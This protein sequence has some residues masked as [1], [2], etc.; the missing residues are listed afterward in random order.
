MSVALA[1]WRRLEE[2]RRRQKHWRRWGTYLSE[3]QWG[4]VREDYSA[5]GTAWDYFPFEHAHLRAYRWGEDGLLGYSDNHGRL[6][7][8]IALWNEK[9][10][11]LKERLFG[12]AGPLGNHGEDVKEIYSYLDATPTGSYAKGLYKYPQRA[13]PYE[14]L[15]RN[16]NRPKH[17]PEFELI[18][19]G[20][21]DDDRYFDVFVEYAK[22][23]DEDV[24]IRVSLVNR[25]PEAAKIHLLGQVFFR[26]EWS[27]G[28]GLKPTLTAVG[29]ESL[30]AHHSS[31]GDYEFTAHGAQR[32]LFTENET[33]VVELYGY[34]DHGGAFRD[35]FGRALIQGKLDRVY[36]QGRGTKAAAWEQTT[37]A[38][39][40][41]AVFYY[42][43]AKKG[44][45][46]AE[47]NSE[48]VFAQ[49]IAE[50]DEFYEDVLSRGGTMN[51]EDAKRVQRQAAAG[52][53]WSKQFYHFSLEDWLK[54]DP[55]QPPPPEA[56]REGRNNEWRHLFNDDIVSM[57]DKW[58]YPWYAAWDL[59]FHMI[60][61]ALI[62]PEFA[63]RQ[64]G[65]FLREWYMHPNGQIPAYEWAFSDVNPPVHA[66]SCWRV[67][68]IDAKLSGKPDTRFL[69]SVFHK[70]LMNFTW[71]VNRK[72]AAGNNIF[73]GGFLGLDNIGIFDR[74][75]PL[76]TG[77]Y[78][79]QSDGTSWMA[80]YCL[81]ML[82][83]AMELAKYNSVYEDIASKF[84]EH[85]LY[86]ANAMN[87]S[88]EHGLW[89]EEDQFYYDR[90]RLPNGQILP[91]RLRSVVGL[92]PLFAVD[93]L[94]PQTINCLP[95]FKSRMEWFIENRPDL[96]ANLASMT[97][98]GMGDRR[99]LSLVGRDRL[100]AL[101]RRM[102]DPNE[103][104][105]DYG[106]RG[107]SKHHEKDPYI[108][109]VGGTQY[110]VDYEPGESQTGLFGGNS[111]WRGPVWFP[112]NYLLI[113]SLQKFS[114]Y[115]GTAIEVECPVGSGRMVTLDVV[116]AEISRR[117]SS[118]FLDGPEGR[119]A[120]RQHP[121]FAG[122]PH[123]RNNVM[124]YEY[125]HGDTGLGL[126]A[127]HQTG[128]TALVAKLMQKIDC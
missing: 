41:T 11:I 92:I 83:I 93:T 96:A 44:L 65:L 74:S 77:G 82:K 108:L 79:E 67:Y 118:L 99:L 49:R 127:S 10:P 72:D 66:W 48:G 51:T 39:G 95:G 101:L 64:L 13:F 36:S 50:A 121:K 116:A 71:W 58:E 47:M 37:V 59:A 45:S 113:E 52:L 119:P 18:D 63:K 110:R 26:N 35:G 100:R 40:G 12:L 55:G 61:F 54:G 5:Y 88:G 14:I 115:H 89:D 75:K 9:D 34:A 16:G 7:F 125:F 70:L 87:G 19:T 24:R 126:G 102:L 114:H 109:E 21:F 60:P 17:E 31:L 94:D 124:F 98:E 22:A 25:G 84:F 105:S 111:N 32:L 3:R 6:C 91:M 81:N 29:E 112:I 2:D 1:E 38:P 42:R 90:L 56:R 27:F 86:I 104:L 107:L 69:E 57:P 85:F 68:K 128:W 23:D 20:I 103:F 97:R 73:E 62:D 33:N 123:F 76:P 53:L 4:T 30:L 78:L 120:M 46:T 122:D 28:R 106:I 15:R 43:L 8:S 117:L 80:M